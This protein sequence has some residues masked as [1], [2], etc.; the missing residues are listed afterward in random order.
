MGFT[1]LAVLDARLESGTNVILVQPDP[2]GTWTPV[3]FRSVVDLG[4]TLIEAEH[5]ADD[6]GL[7]GA[8]V[9]VAD[10]APHALVPNL[11]SAG[12]GAEAVD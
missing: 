9:V 4:L 7:V 6:G 2:D 10:G 5:S 8:E 11:D 3:V 12:L 1:D